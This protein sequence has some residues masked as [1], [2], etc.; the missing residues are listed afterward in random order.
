M[1]SSK[2]IL[3]HKEV[4][5]HAEKENAEKEKDTIQ[6]RFTNISEDVEFTD[7]PMEINTSTGQAHR[8]LDALLRHRSRSGGTVANM[9]R[10]NHG[11][12]VLKDMEAGRRLT[13]GLMVSRGMHSLNDPEILQLLLNKK[14]NELDAITKKKKKESW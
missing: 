2:Q 8:T 14:D 4:L 12:N 10:L 5:Q 9:V 6:I 13:A 7:I 3:L 1:V 11:K